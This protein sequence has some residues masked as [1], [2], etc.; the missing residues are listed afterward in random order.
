MRCT[1][2]PGIQTGFHPGEGAEGVPDNVRLL[3]LPAYS[4]ELNPV[5][6]LGD[7]VKDGIV[8]RLF[9]ALCDMEAAIINEL[10]PWRHNAHLVRHATP[11]SALQTLAGRC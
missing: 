11:S 1:W 8:N 10:E 5:D 4:S 2:W 3:P 9:T 6:P 7:I